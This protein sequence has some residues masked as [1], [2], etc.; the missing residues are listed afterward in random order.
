MHLFRLVWK[1]K[2]ERQSNPTG[3]IRCV[4]YLLG[5]RVGLDEAPC[6][7]HFVLDPKPI[8]QNPIPHPDPIEPEPNPVNPETLSSIQYESIPNLYPS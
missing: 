1:K 6:G 5:G 7:L 4:S 8:S 2:V 3:A